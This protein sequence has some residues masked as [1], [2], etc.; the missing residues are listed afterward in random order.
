VGGDKKREKGQ[1]GRREMVMANDRE[2]GDKKFNLKF[3]DL[4]YT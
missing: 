2:T 4:V 3:H 1:E